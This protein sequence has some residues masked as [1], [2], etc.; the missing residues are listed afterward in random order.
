MSAVVQWLLRAGAKV[1]KK[2]GGGNLA[3]HHAGQ[4]GAES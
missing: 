1:D 4:G 2:D 3:L